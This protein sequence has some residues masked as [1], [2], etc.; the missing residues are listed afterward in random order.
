MMI[1]L[2]LI[3]AGLVALMALPGLPFAVLCTLL[4]CTVLLGTPFSSARA[5]LLPDVLRGKSTRWAQ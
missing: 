5:A 1:T 3:R 4:F 2:D